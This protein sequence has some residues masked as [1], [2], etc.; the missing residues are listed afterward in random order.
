VN[1]NFS[2]TM[3]IHCPEPSEL[4]ALIEK[5]DRA[6]ASSEITAYMG[7]RVLADRAHLGYYT[8]IVDFG[9]IDPDMSAADAAARHNEL[10]QTKAMAAAA[11]ALIDG[12]PEYGHHDEIYRT[13]R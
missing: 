1:Q 9:V 7:T 2:Q 4:L 6:N 10:P 8:V 5:W 3:R 11:A 13:D 12:E